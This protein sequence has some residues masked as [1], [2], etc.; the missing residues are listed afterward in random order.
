MDKR[1]PLT[2]M[3]IITALLLSACATSSKPAAG[4]IPVVATTSILADVVSRVGG[5]LVSVTTLV[6]PGVN[7]H[8]YQPSPRDI[9]AVSDAALVFE[10][11]L[12]LEE[13]MTT[14]IENATGDVNIITVSDGITAMELEGGQEHEED[15]D[16]EQQA[17]TTDP[18]VWLDPANV[19]IWTENIAS[20]LS[21]HDPA[22]SEVYKS[23]SQAYIAKL[24]AL[25][26]WIVAEIARVPLDSRLIVTDHMLFGYF[27]NKYNFT[28][29]GAIIP[30][31]SSMAQPSAQELAALEDAILHYNVRVIL[32]GN[33]VNPALANR[34]ANDTGIK[35]VQFYTGSL[36]AA[37]GP[38]AT[39]L[40]Y[41]RYNVTT[42]VRALS[43]E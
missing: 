14:I 19:I 16:D 29:V 35:L 28:V 7:E 39:Y 26:E 18:H 1:T 5:D 34:I 12:G 11:G 40:D 8:E 20:A 31:Y 15:T 17:H 22:N 43:G 41:M 24:K 25:D 36:S 21:A 13:F 10:V 33:T 6:P 4:K 32:V 23:N 42:I 37:D 38:A 2:I 3:F 9:A 30:S 27:A